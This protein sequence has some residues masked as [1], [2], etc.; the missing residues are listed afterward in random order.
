MDLQEKRIS[1]FKE[2]I[3]ELTNKHY[4]DIKDVFELMEKL[5]ML[6][7]FSKIV[8]SKEEW[9]NIYMDTCHLRKLLFFFIYFQ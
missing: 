9:I 5:Q 1:H 2:E 6:N 4:K 8:W 7:P 3:A